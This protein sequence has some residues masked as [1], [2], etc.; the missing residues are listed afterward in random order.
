MCGGISETRKIASWAES[1]Y[2]QMAPHNVGGPVSTAA[3]LHLAAATP[4]FTIQEHFNDFAEA[5]VKQ[6]APGNPEVVDGY[7]TLPDGPGLG[8]T[9]DEDLVRANPKRTIRFDLYKDNWHL[10]QADAGVDQPA[11]TT[12]TMRDG[13]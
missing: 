5:Y 2:L 9:L 7:F 12:T 10:R 11:T 3:A 8:V 6:V 13:G 1:Y 4:N